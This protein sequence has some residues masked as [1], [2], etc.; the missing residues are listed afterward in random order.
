MQLGRNP[1]NDE[2]VSS[3]ELRLIQLREVLF[4]WKSFSNLRV[5]LFVIGCALLLNWLIPELKS[6]SL[7]SRLKNYMTRAWIALIV[8][9][10]FTF[11]S[12]A[13]LDR[14]RD[15]CIDRLRARY[16]VALKREKQ[17]D[18]KHLIADRIKQEIEELPPI[19]EK[20]REN[21]I[22]LFTN[23]LEY[24]ERYNPAPPPPRE[25]VDPHLTGGPPKPSP[26]PPPRSQWP[27][28]LS[29]ASRDILER[30]SRVADRE[31]FDS[32]QKPAVEPEPPAKGPSPN[33][34]IRQRLERLTTQEQRTKTAEARASE[35]RI[36]A[37]E[38]LAQFLE[39]AIPEM[40][41]L[42]KGY[43]EAVIDYFSDVLVKPGTR[44]DRLTKKAL[45]IL[46]L[47][48]SPTELRANEE[49]HA[50]SNL[51]E[52]AQFHIRRN[53][54][55][56]AL[57]Q[58]TTIRDYFPKTAE[59]RTAKTLLP[60]CLFQAAEQS[61][62]RRDYSQAEVNFNR[63]LSEYPD[64]SQSMLAR[65]RLVAVQ[66]E[67]QKAQEA[68]KPQVVIYYKSDCP[69]SQELIRR[70]LKEQ[71]VA[72]LMRNF[73]PDLVE[74]TENQPRADQ[75]G[76]NFVPVIDIIDSQGV[77]RVIEGLPESSYLADMLKAA[78]SPRRQSGLTFERPD[79]PLTWPR[80]DADDRFGPPRRSS[81]CPMR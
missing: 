36:A 7:V 59:A 66:D 72:D 44:L 15:A 41:D 47:A 12:Q 67:I 34:S 30:A 42:A 80:L 53:E 22:S 5:F 58:L 43:F 63:L 60:E 79:F 45:R 32:E 77:T 33:D 16:E 19:S 57:K 9:T 37:K 75:R 29:K 74:V 56:A 68:R 14:L 27:D 8:V 25:P 73:R 54:W 4:E 26:Q 17:A 49:K 10:S 13:P 55:E 70:T 28:M 69:Y 23:S 24:F 46:R 52:S 51:N 38:V 64:S 81:A 78:L 35:A 11:F 3:L 40:A 20:D 39:L 6:V 2:W 62:R 18:L 50:L 1:A 76:I 71:Q 31:K 21:F 65:E 48:F 61:A